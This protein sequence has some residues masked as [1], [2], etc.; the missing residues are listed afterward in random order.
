M[1]LSN[2][3]LFGAL[4]PLVGIG[5]SAIL[6]I[7]DAKDRSDQPDG[8]IAT[9]D[10]TSGADAAEDPGLTTASKVDVLLVVDDSAGMRDKAIKFGSSLT[11]LLNKVT[12]GQDVHLGVIGTSLGTPGADVCPDSV[13]QVNTRAHLN[14]GTRLSTITPT[15]VL[16]YGPNSDLSS[17]ISNANALV[18]ASIGAGCGLE[19]QLESAYRFLVQP[20]PWESVTVSKAIASYVGTDSELIAQRKAF[21]RPDSLVV[22]VLVTDE[23]DSTADPRSV[24]GQGWAF[25][26][27]TFPGSTQLRADGQQ[28][29][30]PRATSVCATNPGSADCTSCGRAGSCNSSDPACQKLRADPNCA[31]TGGY[32]RPE[33]DSLNTR[34]VRMKQRFGVDPQF[35]ISRYIDGFSNRRVP[36]RDGEHTVSS[37]LMSDYLGT[38]NCTN[39]LFAA[40]LPSSSAEEL[41]NLPVGP[42]G[43]SLVVFAVIGGVPPALVGASPDWQAIIGKN[44]AAYDYTGLSPYMIPSVTPRVG[45]HPPSS[46]RGEVGT[47]AINGREWTTN[48]GDLQYACIYNRKVTLSCLATDNNCDCA[49]AASNPPIC[50]ADLGDEPRDKAYP[51]TRELQVA[52]ALGDRG[53]VGSVCSDTD[54]TATMRVLATRIA[55]RI[56]AQ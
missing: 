14:K 38:G 41:C 7:N 40:T 51:A 10:A 17:F 46:T 44:P 32:Y 42:R 54:Y 8:S 47:D 33:E 45:L 16:T 11:P 20:D 43:K 26:N 36:N 2:R 37:G 15:G 52:A 31:M 35:P 12:L 34:F 13:A 1:R 25:M 23:D 19:A 56:V 27:S 29:T 49:D 39:P 28:T 50:G 5:C 4:V 3:M 9:S 6:G 48:G 30:A 18:T 53:V 21:L 55:P 24:G 22:I